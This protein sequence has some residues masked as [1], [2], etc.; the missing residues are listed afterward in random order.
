M[1]FLHILILMNI[2]IKDMQS[3]VK[4]SVQMK[5]KHMVENKP[6]R[7][8]GSSGRGSLTDWDLAVEDLSGR[9]R[10]TFGTLDQSITAK[11]EGWPDLILKYKSRML[12]IFIF[13][14]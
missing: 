11:F 3:D 10:I 12:N 9:L 13:K 1:N 6:R 8:S 14:I 7:R 5:L 2:F 4:L